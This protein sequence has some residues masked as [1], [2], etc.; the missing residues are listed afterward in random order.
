MDGAALSIFVHF[1]FCTCACISVGN[2]P[3][4][5]GRRGRQRMKCL[6][7]ITDSM[8]MSLSKLWELVMGREAW[9][10][11]VHAVAE[12]QTRLSDWTEL[13][14][15][16]GVAAYILSHLGATPRCFL[17]C[18]FYQVIFLPA[19]VRGSMVTRSCQHLVCGSLILA[20]QGV[21]SSLIIFYW[22]G[23]KVHLWFSIRSYRKTKMTFLASPVTCVS[24]TSNRGWTTFHIFM[25]K[26]Y[27]IF[28]PFFYWVVYWLGL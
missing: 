8:D 14:T 9:C 10:A 4:R 24:L 6:D 2:M 18:W 13:M 3:G 1:T 26:R 23:Q 20:M 25:N 15:S 16:S 11:P 17:K 27:K 5:R 28:C 7:G 21:C 12:G 19:C 22:V